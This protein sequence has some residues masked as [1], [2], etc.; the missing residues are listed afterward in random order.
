[1]KNEYIRL[2]LSY[3]FY[4][5]AMVDKNDGSCAAWLPEELRNDK[6][7]EQLFNEIQE[8]YDSLFIDNEHEF[9]YVGFKS[10]Y[11]QHKFVDKMLLAIALL[12]KKNDGL[13]EIENKI[14][15]EYLIKE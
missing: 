1:M 2:M 13:Y 10:I 3:G 7:L 11:E 14:G 15:K 5:V 9:V 6:E 8:Q 4:P 12:I